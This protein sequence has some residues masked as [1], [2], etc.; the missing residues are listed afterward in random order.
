ME[1]EIESLSQKFEAKIDFKLKRLESQLM[2]YDNKIVSIIDYQNR[3][4]KSVKDDVDSL[5]YKVNKT[6]GGE[7]KIGNTEFKNAQI[8]QLKERFDEKIESVYKT[9]KQLRD[10]EMKSISDSIPT[11]A[12]L[13]DINTIKTSLGEANSKTEALLKKLSMA[14]GFAVA[15]LILAILAMTAGFVL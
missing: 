6:I 4:F 14:Q 12:I 11:D 1:K 2:N 5:R 15:S 9:I 10:E 3:E 13:L 8:E 7:V